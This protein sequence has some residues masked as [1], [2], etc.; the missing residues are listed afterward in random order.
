MTAAAIPTATWSLLLKPNAMPCRRHLSHPRRRCL[1][2]RGLS[3]RPTS[4]PH[5]AASHSLKGR[6]V[7]MQPG[8]SAQACQS[9]R[10]HHRAQLCPF[11]HRA[12]THLPLWKRLVACQRQHRRQRHHRTPHP[13]LQYLPHTPCRHDRHLP[14]PLRQLRPR[15]HVRHLVWLRLARRWARHSPNTERTTPMRL[16]DWGHCRRRLRRQSWPCLRTSRA[17][18]SWRVHSCS[19]GTTSSLTRWRHPVN[20]GTSRKC[21]PPGCASL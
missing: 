17:V 8:Q 11:M 18:A 2:R 7:T 10:R 1:P 21:A 9:R 16:M 14:R 19:C 13:P 4:R 12:V 20:H 3:A 15:R 5:N 6:G